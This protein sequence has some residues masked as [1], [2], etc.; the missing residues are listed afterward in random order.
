MK[1]QDL[2]FR[3]GVSISELESALEHRREQTVL[4]FGL[5]IGS[6]EFEKVEGFGRGTQLAR[7][8]EELVRGERR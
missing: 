3:I 5:C 7:D 1:L 4:L 6:E 8:L 2:V